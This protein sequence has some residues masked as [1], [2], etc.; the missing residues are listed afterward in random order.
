[1]ADG[2]EEPDEDDPEEQF[3]R[4]RALRQRDSEP[5]DNQSTAAPR[6]RLLIRWLA[7]AAALVTLAAVGV[8]VVWQ[9]WLSSFSGPE[10]TPGASGTPGTS[11]TP[12]SSGSPTGGPTGTHHAAGAGSQNCQIPTCRTDGCGSG[13]SQSSDSCD[14]TGNGCGTSGSGCNS[15][16]GG[17]GSSGN[18]SSGSGCGSSGGGSSGGDSC[19][20]GSSHLAGL[21]ADLPATLAHTALHLPGLM[22]RTGVATRL[23]AAAIR[24]YQR[25]LSPRL[26][27]RCRY[28]PNCSRYALA[29]IERYGLLTGAPLAVARIRRCTP[30][31]PPAT[32]DPLLPPTTTTFLGTAARP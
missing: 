30:D 15:S 6:R 24:W 32:A 1:V 21:P 4:L 20:S 22:S 14:S 11:D 13:C 25:H 29:A 27:S 12:A 31:V 3:A 2:T 19:G 18:G 10:P 7:A 16:G 28:E 17:C 8:A 23:G 5:G 9:W 26:P